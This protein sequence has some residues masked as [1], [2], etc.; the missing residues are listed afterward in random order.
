[1]FTRTLRTGPRW[2]GRLIG[3]LQHKKDTDRKQGEKHVDADCVWGQVASEWQR[4]GEMF[5]A[6]R[7]W[8][9]TVC[10]TF[11]VGSLVLG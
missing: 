5:R 10:R 11:T 6:P 9:V 8:H 7:N 1:M 3:N 2:C 4:T